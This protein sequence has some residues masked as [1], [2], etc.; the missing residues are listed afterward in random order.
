[1]TKILQ[2]T[3]IVPSMKFYSVKGLREKITGKGFE[4]I[5]EE[6]LYNNPPNYFIAARKMK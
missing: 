2:K 1:M 4:I 3:G 6:S 5:G